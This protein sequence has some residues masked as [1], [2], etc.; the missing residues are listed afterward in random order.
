M[1]EPIGECVECNSPVYKEF[2]CFRCDEGPFCPE[3]LFA[4]KDECRE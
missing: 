3:H 4:H 2:R 1:S